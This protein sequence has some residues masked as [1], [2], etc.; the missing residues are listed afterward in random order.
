M[1]DHELETMAPEHLRAGVR[2]STASI[3]WT[4]AA[5]VASVA[6]GLGA[7]SLVLVAFGLTGLLDA[8]AWPRSSPTSV[9]RF[10]TKRSLSVTSSGRCGL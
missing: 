2:S 9:T 7:K 8:A 10:A 4:V 1:H 5:S 6:L 3:A